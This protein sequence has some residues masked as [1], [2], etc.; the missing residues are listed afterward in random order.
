MDYIKLALKGFFKNKRLKIYI[1]SISLTLGM[2]ISV[3]YSMYLL[4][5]VLSEKIN[6][7]IVNRVISISKEE[8]FSSEELDRITKITNAKFVYNRLKNVQVTFND[9]QQLLLSYVYK[10]EIPDISKGMSIQNTQELQLVLPSK[11]YNKGQL[12]DL[13]NYVGKN[14]IFSY[15]DIIIEAKVVGTYTAKHGEAIAY[16]NESLKNKLVEYN[17]RIIYK[18]ALYVVVDEYKNVDNVIKT[19][20]EEY[21]YTAYIPN[22]TGQRDI[23]L[24]NITKIITFALILFTVLFIYISISIIIGNIISDEKMDIAILKA[25]GYKIKDIYIIMRYRILSVIGISFAISCIIAIIL[26]NILGYII[27]YKLDISLQSR[28]SL[29]ILTLLFFTLCVYVI[30]IISVRLNNRKIKKINTIDLLKEN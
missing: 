15:E 23:K 28:F 8:E 27:K 22:T 9:N 2:A 12:L 18:D 10:E 17:K 25:L 24:Y 19:I 13:E 14:I 30:S 5:S 21:N 1:I 6:N 3:I 26:N 11:I 20:K 29:F 4:N 16:I 7:N